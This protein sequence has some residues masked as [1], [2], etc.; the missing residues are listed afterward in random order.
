MGVGRVGYKA[1]FVTVQSTSDV[2][3][4]SVNKLIGSDTA[5]GV[6]SSCERVSLFSSDWSPAVSVLVEVNVR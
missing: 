3:F 6:K 1:T 4:S 2:S 5:V